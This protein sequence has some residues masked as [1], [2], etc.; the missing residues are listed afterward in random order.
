MEKAN[1]LLRKKLKDSL[2]H[3]SHQHVKQNLINFFDSVNSKK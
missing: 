2:E 1:Y 3:Q